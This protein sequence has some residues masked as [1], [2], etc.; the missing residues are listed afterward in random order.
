MDATEFYKLKIKKARNFG[1]PDPIFINAEY[2]NGNKK[3]LYLVAIQAMH[4]PNKKPNSTHHSS[5]NFKKY[6]RIKND[7]KYEWIEKSIETDK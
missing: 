5:L 7:G 4:I 3:I 2:L 6:A 1:F